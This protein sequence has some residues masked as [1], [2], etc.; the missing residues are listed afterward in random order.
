MQKDEILTI[1]KEKR[2][3]FLYTIG[4]SKAFVSM[5]CNPEAIKEKVDKFRYLKV[6]LNC[7]HGKKYNTP[8]KTNQ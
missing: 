2:R 6:R 1:I 8:T 3:Q 7:L 5:I 4:V